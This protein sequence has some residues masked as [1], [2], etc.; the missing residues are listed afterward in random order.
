MIRRGAG[1]AA[2]ALLL[3]LGACS[4][5]GGGAAGNDNT[6][7][8]VVT[9]GD[10]GKLSTKVTVASAGSWRWYFPGTTTT[11]LK[12]SAADVLNLK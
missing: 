3:A 6:A 2:A 12:V 1:A 4:G 11:S 9:T 5:K 8:E 10:A 7:D